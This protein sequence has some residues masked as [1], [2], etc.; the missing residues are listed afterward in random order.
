MAR[1]FAEIK[2][3]VVQRVV[4]ADDLQWCID[5]LGGTWVETFM[6]KPGH[7]YAGLGFTHHPD[8]NNFSDPQPFPSWILDTD[9][10]WQPP[11]PRPL[12]GKRYNWDENSQSWKVKPLNLDL[13]NGNS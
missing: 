13:Q 2:N 11:T 9:C 1:Y 8:K 6:D 4:V 5:N 12:D 10:K 3:N 7:N